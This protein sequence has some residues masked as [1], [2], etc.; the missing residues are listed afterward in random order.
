MKQAD[1]MVRPLLSVDFHDEEGH[2][3]IQFVSGSCS[4]LDRNRTVYVTAH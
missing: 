2:P 3:V 4:H 1:N